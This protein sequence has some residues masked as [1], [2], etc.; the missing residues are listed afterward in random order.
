MP[1]RKVLTV[2]Q[3]FEILVKWAETKDWEESLYSVIPQRKFLQ[4]ESKPITIGGNVVELPKEDAE[5]TKVEGDEATASKEADH[6]K[7]DD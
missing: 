5:L 4:D 1:T 3:C 6:D 7:T 2:N